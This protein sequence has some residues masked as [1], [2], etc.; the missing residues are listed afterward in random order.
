[1]HISYFV[2]KKLRQFGNTNIQLV[3]ENDECISIPPKRNGIYLSD[4]KDNGNYYSFIIGDNGNGK[5][6]LL[7]E[8]FRHSGTWYLTKNGES[9]Y[10]KDFRFKSL[11]IGPTIE[12]QV[13]PS[14]KIQ[15][16]I[17]INSITFKSYYYLLL[18]FREY[19]LAVEELGKILHVSI[20]NQLKVSLHVK[21]NP[22]ENGA[23][24]RVRLPKNNGYSI[25]D[26][27]KI[28]GCESIKSLVSLLKSIN[29]DFKQCICSDEIINIFR[30][31]TAWNQD[32]LFNEFIE[33]CSFLNTHTKESRCYVSYQELQSILSNDR[34]YTIGD[35]SV[36][37]IAFLTFL[38]ELGLIK[39]EIMCRPESGSIEIPLSLLSSGQQQMVK[40]FSY[41]SL[42][43]KSIR[44]NV[45]VLF[46]EPELSLHPK[47]QL[48]FPMSLKRI[49]EIYN[50]KD[51]HFV[52]A[53]HSPLIIMRSSYLKNS[54]VVK[55]YPEDHTLKGV[56]IDN[57]NRYNLVKL[58]FDEF[59]FG[60]YDSDEQQKI[61]ELLIKHIEWSPNAENKNLLDEVTRSI[62]VRDDIN[63][64]YNEIFDDRK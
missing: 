55:L 48:D 6:T 50:I 13:H 7:R 35:M 33:I 27:V 34:Y 25:L 62:D 54:N 31:Q 29:I 30:D 40:L 43:P 9:I 41:L 8:L 61:K 16:R 11:L 51:S 10:Q 14:E 12:P 18:Y 22:I 32:K 3:K 5:T 44:K 24:Y 45:L 23:R 47:W 26:F 21:S 59:D 53:T 42:V 60:Y 46:D 28:F 52:I 63:R 37:E 1:M 17:S 2:S 49:V 56:I 15:V 20:S 4:N 36:L 58:L 39:I 38:D 64:L 19:P 57:I